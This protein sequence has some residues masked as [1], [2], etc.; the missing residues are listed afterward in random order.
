MTTLTA[1]PF[2][3]V[4]GQPISL[5]TLANGSGLEVS[6]TNYGAIVQ[7][8]RVPDR[9]G[10]MA[11]I[12]LGFDTL[13]DYVARN[14]PYFGAICG[15]VANRIAGGR[16]TLDG[17]EYRLAA[18][19][20]LNAL[21]GGMKGFDKRVWTADP[22]TDGLRLRLVSVD[23]EE[24]YP[25]ELDLRVRYTLS[26]DNALV[27]DYEATATRATPVNLTN[28]TYFN[29]AGHA[30][31]SIEAHVLT[32]RAAHHTQFDNTL[33]PT[34]AIA[35]VAGTPLDFRTPHAIGERIGAASGYDNN[36]VL[37]AGTGPCARVTDPA[38]GRILE[39]ET[40]EPGVQLYTGNFLDNVAG[41]AGA[42]YRRHGGLCLE[43]QHFPDSVHHPHFPGTILRPGETYTQ[44]T[45][46]RFAAS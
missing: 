17:R 1:I 43:A 26:A 13:A 25:G 45:A 16:F 39:M 23:G 41:K 10:D 40:T 2:G 19:D 28:H 30:A 37:D 35:P 36:F 5:Y 29:L 15:R 44:R 18:N 21:H 32:L 22:V 34:G 31:G 7:A 4:D 14:A 33:T 46:Y 27:I 20:G 6:I 3:R 12:A 8:I 24:G 9:R 38:T 42:V 11:D